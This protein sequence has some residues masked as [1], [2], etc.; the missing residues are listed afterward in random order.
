MPHGN[1]FSLLFQTQQHCT[2]GRWPTRS[3]EVLLDLIRNAQATAE[4]KQLDLNRLYIDHLAA[5]RAPKLRRRKYRAHGRITPY[6]TNPS[7]VELVLRQRPKAVRKPRGAKK[8]ETKAE[9]KA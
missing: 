5:Q 7:H 6:M 1:P 9:P 4:L 8:A 2:Q 3:C